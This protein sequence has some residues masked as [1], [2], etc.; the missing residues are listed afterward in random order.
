MDIYRQNI[1]KY[2]WDKFAKKYDPFMKNLQQT[3]DL[4][5]GKIKK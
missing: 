2:F 5:F 1:E 3:Y 4:L